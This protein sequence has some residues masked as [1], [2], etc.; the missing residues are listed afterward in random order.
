MQL[1]TPTGGVA[2]RYVD[3]PGG[4]LRRWLLHLLLRLTSKHSHVG[5]D[6]IE[7][8]R[9][10]NARFDARLGGSGDAQRRPVQ[11]GAVAC[12]WIEVPASRTDRT[13]LYLH[14]GAFALRLPNTHAALAAR[15]CR[16]LQ[17]RALMVDY[18]LAPEHRHPAGLVDCIAAYRWL[19]AQG[20]PAD[21]I[22]IAGDSAGANLALCT[23]QALKSAS[24]PLPRCAVLLSPVVDFTLSSPSLRSNARSDPMFRLT[25]L[26]ALRQLYADP[27]H[28]LDAAISPLFGSFA[29]LPPLLFHAG[30]IE[31]L[32]DESLRAA[33]AASRAGVTVDVAVWRR[34]GHVFHAL[35]LPQ[36][37]AADADVAA[38]VQRHA[39]WLTGQARAG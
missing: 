35:P 18:R 37:R 38:F 31:M 13:L 25:T 10:H 6:P 27:Q 36:A 8:L 17:A 30:D 3:V 11:A 1:Q 9:Q 28:Y 16:R 5:L 15:W 32:R 19:L 4:T 22:V 21:T 24:D 20:I 12:E 26:M 29:G 14:G 33:T 39:G 34:M 23:L 7:R 2:V